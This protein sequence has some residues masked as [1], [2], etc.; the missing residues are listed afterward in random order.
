MPTPRIG[1]ALSVVKGNIYAIGGAGLQWNDCCFYYYKALDTN[2]IYD[3]INDTWETKA[4]MITP[5]HHIGVAVINDKIFVCGGSKGADLWPPIDTVEVYSPTTDT[6]ET[7]SSMPKRLTGF[8][9]TT[10]DEKFYIIGG[11]S[12]QEYHVNDTFVYDPMDAQWYNMSHMPTKR[13]GLGVCTLDGIIY[14]I[15]GA[16]DGLRSI[17]SKRNNYLAENEEFTSPFFNPSSNLNLIITYPSENT[18]LSGYTKI[19]GTASDA[20]GKIQSVQIR[21]DSKSWITANG[22]ESWSYNLD[23]TTL[24]EGNHVISIRSFDKLGNSH[25]EMI[26]VTVNNIKESENETTGFEFIIAFCALIL[27]LIFKRKRKKIE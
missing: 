8:G 12:F 26:N 2:E 19:Y 7:S 22:T 21:I 25:R 15:G 10:L 17:F 4:P 24:E 18:L 14:A 13:Y 5:R 27:I 6:W 1:L 20:N 16:N 9:I 23:T 3:P 11:L